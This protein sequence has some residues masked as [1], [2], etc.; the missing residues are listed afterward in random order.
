MPRKTKT[1]A[2]NDTKAQII[3]ELIRNSAKIIR[4]IAKL[5]ESIFDS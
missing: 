1:K 3:M 2:G 5:R 4:A